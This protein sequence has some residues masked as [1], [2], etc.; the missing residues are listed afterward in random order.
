MSET[1]QSTAD[2]QEIDLSQISKK[3]GS[4]FETI[5][6]TIFRSILFFKRNIIWIGILFFLGLVLGFFLDKS[7]KSYESQI[8]VCP[9]FA[10]TD[11]LYTKIDL[12]NS[13]I[14]DNDTVFLR[15][16]VG[17][18]NP[19][20]LSKIEIKPI[21][22]VYKFAENRDKDNNFE[23]LKL[24]A[25]DGDIKKIV[26]ENLTSK[27]YPYHVIVFKT[28]GKTDDDKTVKPILRFLN[29]SPYFK[30]IQKQYL[31]NIKIKIAE[32]DSIIKQI[33]T[34]LN[35][36]SKTSDGSQKSDKLVYYNENSQLGDIIKT[37]NELNYEQGSRRMDL[38]NLDKI[39]KDNSV[40]LNIKNSESIFGK[41]KFL[42]P[43]LFIFLF[44]GGG[45][46]KRY[47]RKQMV[48]LKS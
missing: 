41:M 19:K 34:I 30:S 48:K 17:I 14:E 39:I 6:T 43:V 36:F 32:N 40:T 37:K 12:I 31:N 11:Y 47:Y 9:N 29:N 35:T 7:S 23:L 5:A 25:E 15:D 3:I 46:F 27:N 45:A 16:I 13:K 1:S 22:D 10:S 18:K 44:I 42:L 2:N 26:T 20:K 21:I 24:M 4:F 38:I 8:I 28:K 33:N